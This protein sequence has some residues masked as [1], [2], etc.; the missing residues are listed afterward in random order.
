MVSGS[1][2]DKQAHT[3]SGRVASAKLLLTASLSCMRGVSLP[4]SACSE[5]PQST[6][7]ET[8]RRGQ[9]LSLSTRGDT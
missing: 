7:T 4:G 8:E 3:Y 5:R 1:E 9:A 6:E 2:H